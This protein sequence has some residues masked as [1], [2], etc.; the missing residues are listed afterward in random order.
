MVKHSH[1]LFAKLLM[2]CGGIDRKQFR[3][4]SSLANNRFFIIKGFYNKGFIT[5]LYILVT[6]VDHAVY[7]IYI[8]SYVI[9]YNYRT[10]IEYFFS[11]APPFLLGDALFLH[12][13]IHDTV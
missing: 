11:D 9:I 3:L 12:F 13:S 7:I 6:V 1:A 2:R 5:K 10:E 8:F 4:P